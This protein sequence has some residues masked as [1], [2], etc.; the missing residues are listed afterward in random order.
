M[1]TFVATLVLSAL[2]LALTPS[3]APAEEVYI[4][5]TKYAA[6]AYSPKTGTSG[7]AWNCWTREE[8]ERTALEQC[9]EP[10]AKVMVWVQYGWAVLLIAEDGSYASG[11][12]YGDGCSPADAYKN[13]LKQLRTYTQTRVVKAIVVCSGNVAPR[14]ITD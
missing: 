3:T 2:A 12:V 13:A 10:D 9:N 14:V 4:D 5:G 8:A 7:Y 1:K 11:F 6:I